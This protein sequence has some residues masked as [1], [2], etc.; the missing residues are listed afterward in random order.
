MSQAVSGSN[1][2]LKTFMLNVVLWLPLGFFLWFYLSAVLV[3]PVEWMLRALLIGGY[4]EYFEELTREQYLLLPGPVL[5]LP[6]GRAVVSFPVNP[7]VYGYGLPLIGALIMS[8]PI[9]VKRRLVQLLVG[10][11]AIFLVQS[12]GSFW[13]TFRTLAFVLEHGR[14]LVDAAGISATLIALCYQFGYLI[15]PSVV[16]IALWIALNRS[17]IESLIARVSETPTTNNGQQ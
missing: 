15:L 3:I 12:W 9:S 4:S 5:T 6:E 13:E 11:L 10:F 2:S 1:G 7:M 17:F 14:P 8:T 16:P